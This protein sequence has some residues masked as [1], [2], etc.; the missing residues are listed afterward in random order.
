[1]DQLFSPEELTQLDAYH[2]PWW[3]YAAV[4]AVALP[5]TVALFARFATGPVYA[6]AERLAAR[7]SPPAVLRRVGAA[8]WGGPGLGA[9]LVFAFAF[10]ELFAVLTFPA[11]VYFGYVRERDFGLTPQP[12]SGWLG[13]WLKGHVVGAFFLAALTLGLFGL[14]RRLER[15]WLVLG[16]V[17]GV[18]L[19]GSAA[20]DP[21]RSQLYVTQRPLEA[22]ALRTAL[23]AQLARGGV[24]FSDIVVDETSSRSVRL[25]AYFA[26]RGPTRRIVLNDALLKALAPQG[27]AA[28]VAH[29]MGHVHEP[30]W[31]NLA[32]S[33]VALLAFLAF[34]ERLF[35]W[36]VARRWAGATQRGDVRA[37]PL[38]VLTFDLAM[39][40]ASPLAAAHSRQRELDA[41]EYAIHLTGDATVFRQMLV[42]AARTNR[43]HPAPPRWYVLKGVSHPPLAERLANVDRLARETVPGR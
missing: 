1:M 36:C 39:A 17:G 13:D 26:G 6:W 14:A 7:V 37:L 3:T 33:A 18:G 23:E 35:R 20:I 9:A 40:A 25:Q 2:G 21:Y 10:F 27:V 43:M 24:E 42:I 30:R 41:D 5:L 31:P 19:I 28:A 12:L 32:A 29:E 38:I 16:V 11:D 8:L 15:W 4:S 22:G 34:V